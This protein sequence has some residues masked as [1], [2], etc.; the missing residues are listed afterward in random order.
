MQ[1]WRYPKPID[2]SMHIPTK[3]EFSVVHAYDERNGETKAHSMPSIAGTLFAYKFK[4]ISG[5]ILFVIT[6]Y[7]RVLLRPIPA[8]R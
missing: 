5:E 3:A 4:F 6:I 1:Y 2:H 8:H 7:P